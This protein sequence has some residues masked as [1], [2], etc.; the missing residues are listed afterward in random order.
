MIKQTLVIATV[1]AAGL[2][3][4]PSAG[5]SAVLR[6]LKTISLGEFANSFTLRNALDAADCGIGDAE[7]ILV[8][9]AFTFGKTD[10]DGAEK[11]PCD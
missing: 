1:C 11:T 2:A 5:L 4:W 10:V 6:A 3:L 7:E 9:P 8:R